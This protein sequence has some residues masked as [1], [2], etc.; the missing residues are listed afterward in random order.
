MPRPLIAVTA[1]I[2]LL[3]TAF[4]PKD[5]TKLAV[6]YTEALYAAG[7]QPVILPVTQPAPLDLLRRFDGLVLTGGGDLDPQLYGAQPDP[8]VYGIRRERD[9]F[10]AALYAEAT[11]LGLPI[12]A[13]CRGMQLINVLRGGD[14][15]QQL[16]P[17]GG[18][19]QLGPAH[20]ASHSVDILA[21]S[22][23]AGLLG[24][25]DGKV[26]SYHHQA[27]DRLGRDLAATATCGAVV[28]A[29]EATDADLLGVQW[30]PEHMASIDLAQ[31]A[32][33]TDFIARSTAVR[34]HPR[35][36]NPCPTL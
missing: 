28:E 13:I 26:N 24:G 30:H 4:G 20:E 23:L 12:L 14:L 3:D 27:L 25:S 19:W 17:A 2:E 1:P 34:R 7:G 11:A 35:E 36:E 31:Q 5:C 8:T 32:I 10:E 18:H 15:I 6:A 29:V 21:G 33:F 22:R 9:D 16:E